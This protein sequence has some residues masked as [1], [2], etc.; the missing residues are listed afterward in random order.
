MMFALFAYVMWIPVLVALMALGIVLIRRSVSAPEWM[1]RGAG[2]GGCGY[3]LTSLGE[4]RCPE[5]GAALVKVGVSTPRMALR[6]RGSVFLLVMG[7]TMAAGVGTTP[8]LGVVGWMAS[9]AQMN[10]WAGAGMGGSTSGTVKVSLQPGSGRQW[11][12]TV[13]RSPEDYSIQFVADVVTDMYASTTEGTVVINFNDSP[14]SVTLE[15]DLVDFDWTLTDAQG[16]TTSQGEYFDEQ[17]SLEVFEAAGLDVEKETTAEEAAYLSSA[18]QEF[19]T[20]PQ[21]YETAVFTSTNPLQSTSA[22]S[23]WSPIVGVGG[24]AQTTSWLSSWEIAFIG[25]IIVGGVVYIVG[26]VFFIRKRT[27]LLRQPTLG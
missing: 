22:S 5:C 2:C 27:K 16:N 4:G 18:L 20:M 1:R 19:V 6:L 13:V 10:Q 21:W 8:V 11:P 7:W 9:T 12:S 15:V 24:G 23:G 26:L 25:T 3:E 17:A 14:Q